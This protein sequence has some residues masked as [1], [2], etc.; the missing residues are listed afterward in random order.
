MKKSVLFIIILCWL[1]A[2]LSS[3]NLAT[4]AP[5]E[6]Q[7]RSILPLPFEAALAK[8]N[9][10]Y[11]TPVDLSPDGQMVAYTIQETHNQQS[12][13]KGNSSVFSTTGVYL[14]LLGCNVWVSNVESGETRNLTSSRGTSWGP[15]WS[16]DGEQLAFYSDRSGEQRVW[17][18]ERKTGELRQVGDAM[19][20]ASPSD[21]IRWTPDGTGIVIRV[22]PESTT[23]QQ[24]LSVNEP[25]SEQGASATTETG[26]AAT[27]KV[28]RSPAA[29]TD[30]S[31]SPQPNNKSHLNNNIYRADVALINVRDGNLR[32]V[33]R[34]Y[35]PLWCAISPDGQFV[36]FTSYKGLESDKETQPLFDLII[37][38]LREGK[39]EP[40]ILASNIRFEAGT[41]IS[42][43]PDGKRLA[44][45]TGGPLARGDCFIVSTTGGEPRNLTTY[46]HPDFSSRFYAPLWDATGQYIYLTANMRGPD[47]DKL[48]KVTLDGRTIP[49]AHIPQ[50]R[51]LNIVAPAGVGRFWSP[52]EQM[53]LVMTRD[54][55]TKQEGLYQ[56][57]LR[58][59]AARKLREGAISFGSAPLFKVDVSANGGRIIYSSQSAGQSED[60]WYMDTSDLL[61]PPRQVTHANPQL[62]KYQMGESR[63][64]A[65]QSENGQQLQG[66][67]LLPSG[68]APGK[69]YPL[70]VTQYPGAMRSN[71]ANYYGF[72]LGN[73]IDDMQVLATRGYAVLAPDV[74]IDPRSAV[75]LDIKKAVLPGIRKVIE[76]GIA[77]PDRLGVIGHSFGGY[78][79]LSLIVQTTQ[80]KAAVDSA[81]VSNMIGWYGQLDPNG[82]SIY[83]GQVENLVTTGTLWEKREKFIENSPV[84]FL[85]KVQTPLLILQGTKDYASQTHLS[86]Q[87]FVF[88]RRLGKP[89]EYAKYTN[90]VHAP[91]IWDYANQKDYLQRMVAWLD[92]WLKSS[93]ASTSQAR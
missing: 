69:R 14:G 3:E 63:V 7:K 56:I 49:F 29:K 31:L 41:T 88:L 33:G 81:G 1:I 5:N 79:V 51:I 17:I 42:W 78:G 73:G 27:V 76:M 35:Q 39:Y 74:P 50:K 2:T 11:Q 92:R 75:M 52:Q 60:I 82:G 45:I 61:A 77:D 37:I 47:A 67:L 36:A 66:A 86:D 64:I 26:G 9:F 34:G 43:S 22:W 93:A 20:R 55:L 10:L 89:V 38:P 80:F 30:E 85:D 24:W 54:D 83:T 44:Y 18:W 46:P 12:S 90:E 21:V 91:F 62:D 53:L 65:W 72:S 6:Q 59:G 58:T 4:A 15:V 48:W 57:D 68:Y 71:S 40:H 28:Y 32:R 8:R 19:V 70:I 16:P 25:E 87:V 23:L 84:F 13:A